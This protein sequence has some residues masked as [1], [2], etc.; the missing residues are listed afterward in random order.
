MSMNKRNYATLGSIL[1]DF[2]INALPI[3]K[4]FS[5]SPGF[6]FLTHPRDIED[7]YRAAPFLKFFRK[8]F[9]D[10]LIYRLITLCPVYSV[11]KISWK[12]E[13]HGLVVSTPFLPSDLFKSRDRLLRITGKI[14]NY[15][16]KISNSKV[17]IGLAAWWPIVTNNGLAF[18]RFLED[19]DRLVVTNGHTATLISI[20]LTI[21]RLSS[22]SS[23]EMNNLNI[24]ILGVGR[25]GEAVA[26]VLND[27]VNKIGLSDKNAIRIE[28]VK[29]RLIKNVGSSSQIE[30]H[31]LIEQISDEDLSAI[32]SKYDITV[33]TTSNTNYIINKATVLRNC[34]IIDDSRPEAFPRII[35]F[36][37]RAAVLEGGLMKIEGIKTE[38]DFGFGKDDNVF[39]CLAEA[40]ILALDGGKNLKPIVGEID[41]E[42]LQSMLRFCKENNIREGD[43]LS[44]G[45]KISV[46]EIKQLLN[47]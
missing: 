6:I 45:R 2:L 32:L 44:G 25:V 39:G 11:V 9:P 41:F 43:I 13:L 12:D 27:K 33:C 19:Q 18:R 29:N 42:N 31:P 10:S 34:I 16:R 46:S 47:R 22:I 7:I 4:S 1:R 40:V 35:D 36:E 3:K 5:P 24:M 15:I 28:S 17:Y 26:Q 8:I 37:S 38:F 20:Y 23:I 21:K 14:I 30:L